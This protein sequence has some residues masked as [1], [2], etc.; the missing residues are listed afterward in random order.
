MNIIDT[1]SNSPLAYQLG[2][3]LVHFLWQGVVVGVLYIALRHLLRKNSSATRY[4]LAMGTLVVMVAL[5]VFT[6]MHL[7]AVTSTASNGTLQTL[8]G[9]TTTG[10]IQGVATPLS[11]LNHLKIW[12]QPLVPWTVPLWLLGVLFMALRVWYGWRHANR[13]RKTAA[14]IPLPEWSTV[15]ES[16]RTLLGIRKL[17]RLAV[18]V[19]ITVPSVIGW[20]K[21]IILLPPS[22]IAGLTPLQM[23]LILAHELV[24]IRRQDYLWNLL[25][26]A[27]ETLLFYHPMVRW[28]SHQARLEREQ[29]CDDM[30]VKLHGNAIDYARALAELESLRHPR[31][32]FVLGAN[33]GQVLERIH[34]LL[35]QPTTNA[36]MS[37]LPL[38]LAAG[39]LLA[40][41][42]MT[43]LQQKAPLQSVLAAK[44]TL[45]DEPEQNRPQPA[46]ISATATVPTGIINIALTRPALQRIHTLRAPGKLVSAPL[47]ALP[48]LATP[49]QADVAA[50]TA[51]PVHR[52]PA[53]NR[54]GG[55]VI[56]QYSPTY[57]PLALERGVE[58]SATV[59]F[60]L[61]Q[62]GEVTDVRVSQVNGS[63]LFGPAAMDAIR[64]WRFAPV[65]IEDESVAQHM[66]IEFEFRLNGSATSGGP[67]KIPMGYHVCTN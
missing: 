8:A 36:A 50:P 35:G 9:M 59:E 5:P 27:V 23:E 15:V 56:A 43:V 22:V 25:Q 47:L 30:V 65:T 26:I 46:Q 29:C 60:T 2:W 14:F 45:T 7:H 1:L 32:A 17:V 28:V 6:F 21:P 40:G 52:V 62:E 53:A 57:P 48:A 34:R 41:S 44:Y 58:G 19:S 11:V 33:G 12:L 67:C 10:V 39:L 54:G 66:A 4:R 64:R 13:L 3:T 38:L 42:F 49:A 63:R 24:H 31:T 55:T 51:V 20:L 61:T 16:L 18:S 37:W